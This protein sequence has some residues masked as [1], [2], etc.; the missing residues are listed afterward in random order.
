MKNIDEFSLSCLVDFSV[1][2]GGAQEPRLT[3]SPSV[4]VA[5]LSINGGLANTPRSRA[6]SAMCDWSQSRRTTYCS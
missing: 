1:Q 2:F 4:R 5:D 6:R 3:R